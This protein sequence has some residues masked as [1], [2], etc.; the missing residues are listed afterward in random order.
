MKTQKT[1]LKV[2]GGNVEQQGRLAVRTNCQGELWVQHAGCWFSVSGIRAP[3]FRA[4]SQG[5]A[6]LWCK[7]WPFCASQKIPLSASALVSCFPV[8]ESRWLGKDCKEQR[9]Y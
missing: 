4:V 1:F 6:V 9:K 2:G 8:S 7:E 3:G 5:R